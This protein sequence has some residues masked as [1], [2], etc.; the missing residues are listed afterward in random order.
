MNRRQTPSSQPHSLESEKTVLGALILDPEAILKVHGRLQP[1]D[2]YDPIYRE[3]Y[4]AIVALHADGKP[5]DFST[6]CAKLE[7]HSKI[8]QIGGPAFLADLPASVPTSSHIE[9]YAD[10]VIEKARLRS[11]IAAGQAITALGFEQEGPFGDKLHEAE[12]KLFEIS[13]V[14]QNSKPQMICSALDK[15]Y[16]EIA[17]IQQSGDT[18]ILR[19]V[20]S[21]LSNIDYFTN[22][23]APGALCILA[24]RP[25]MGKTAL[26]LDIALHAAKKEGKSTLFFSLEMSAAELAD[27]IV[28]SQISVSPWKIE[29]GD[30]T[31]EEVRQ[32][33][34][35]VEHVKSWPL[36]LDDDHD[37]SLSNLRTKALEHKMEHGLDLLIIDYLQLVELP[38][39]MKPKENFQQEI[40]V[41]SRG[42][43]KLA[44][45]LEVPILALS[46][47][48]RSVENTPQNIPQLSHLRESGKIEEDAHL[49]MMLWREGYYNEDCEHPEKTSVFIRKN[50]QG[51][52][53]TTELVFNKELMRFTPW[54][55]NGPPEKTVSSREKSET[56]G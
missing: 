51:P 37:T 49:V 30:L 44:R 26:A 11:L 53:G 56:A 5:I 43:K 15:R 50:R 24:A 42:L 36:Y 54:M 22:G 3:I 10:T 45:E 8:D 28:G 55:D 1:I 21:G 34:D 23:F 25:G 33:G 35:T 18:S 14:T 52:V 38:Q 40:S 12:S 9:A 29:K 2:F 27:R 32:I 48:N 41:I 16:A 20:N 13:T 19:R 39:G 31:D 17:E 46:Q 6:V 4:E 47:L 7:S